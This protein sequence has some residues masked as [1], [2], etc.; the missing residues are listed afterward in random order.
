[1][2]MKHTLLLIGALLS[3]QGCSLLGPKKAEL[4]GVVSDNK[5][6]YSVS[7]KSPRGAFGYQCSKYNKN[8]PTIDDTTF[9]IINDRYNFSNPT[10]I[11]NAVVTDLTGTRIN[12]KHI[13]SMYDLIPL[14]SI[15]V[16]YKRVT[17]TYQLS[18]NNFVLKKF[19]SECKSNYEDDKQAHLDEIENRRKI[20]EQYK[21]KVKQLV[22]KKL[23]ELGFKNIPNG[24]E[25]ILSN[26]LVHGRLSDQG[27]RYR[28]LENKN[29]AYY[30]DFSS[31]IVTQQINNSTYML[32]NLIDIH[33]L[34]A[35]AHIELLPIIFHSKK[36]LFE[37]SDVKPTIVIYKGVET[38]KNIY[39]QNKQAV[40]ITEL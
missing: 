31:Y 12:I 34:A 14:S 17:S 16:K 5:D 38:Y 10:N 36:Q 37:Q 9:S 40:V 22:A 35:Q 24:G 30:M 23:K 18:F 29:T 3:I 8:H 7:F 26:T 39:G 28:F 19:I 1:M 27:N 2:L 15:L 33:G 13:Q 4:I 32:R 11:G 25:L 21:T 20:K 6:F